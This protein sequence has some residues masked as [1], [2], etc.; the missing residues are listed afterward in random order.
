MAEEITPLG[1]DP[2]AEATRKPPEKG[3]HEGNSLSPFGHLNARPPEQLRQ[4]WL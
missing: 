2:D 1:R 3:Q 4:R